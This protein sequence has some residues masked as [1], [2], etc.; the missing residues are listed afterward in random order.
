[1]FRKKNSKTKTET[2]SEQYY[3]KLMDLSARVHSTLDLDTALEI[4]LAAALDLTAMERGY[5]MLYNSSGKLEFRERAGWQY[6]NAA[7][8]AD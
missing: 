6:A 8:D 2:P 1:M 4:V 5:I 3:E 7:R